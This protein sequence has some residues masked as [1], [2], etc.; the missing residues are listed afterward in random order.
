MIRPLANINTAPDARKG[1]VCE[2]ANFSSCCAPK[3]TLLRQRH[4]PVARGRQK[5][6]EGL[7][8]SW[9]II[10]KP[11]MPWCSATRDAVKRSPSERKTGWRVWR[12]WQFLSRAASN[13]I[14]GASGCAYEM[15][16]QRDRSKPCFGHELWS[17][18]MHLASS[19]RSSRF[20]LFRSN[21]M[22]GSAIV[23]P[24]G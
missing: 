16:R 9:T 22:V 10:Q 17:S 12:Q 4:R 15:R 18:A 2:E 23:E 20:D 3:A 1:G 19:M 14:D 6:A 5:P 7:S 24:G 8:S 21:G 13:P 11:L